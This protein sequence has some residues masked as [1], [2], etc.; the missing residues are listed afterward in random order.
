MK[1]K[2]ESLRHKFDRTL[3]ALTLG[4]GF[5]LISGIGL[6]QEE[7][8]TTGEIEQNLYEIQYTRIQ[9][10]LIQ[11]FTE[12]QDSLIISLIHDA[13]DLARDSSWTE[14]REILTTVEMLLENP[15]QDPPLS[16]HLNS[17]SVTLPSEIS[18]TPGNSSFQLE[19]GVDYSLQEY[20]LSFLESDSLLID[21]LQNPYIG[22]HFSHMLNLGTLPI[23]FNH[24]L[25]VD[26]QYLNY[27]LFSFLEKARTNSLHRVD[28]AANLFVSQTHLD[29]TFMDGNFS[30]LWGNPYSF[31]NRW[32]F[33]IRNRIKWYPQPQDVSTNIFSGSATMFYEHYFTRPHSLAITFSP[34]YYK[35]WHGSLYN[36]FRNALDLEYQYRVKYNRFIKISSRFELNN[37]RNE[38]TDSLYKNKYFQVQPKVEFEVELKSHFGVAGNLE[39]ERKLYKTADAISPDETYLNISLVPKIYLGELNSFGIGGFWE[40]LTNQARTSSEDQAFARQ[41]NYTAKGIQIVAEYIQFSGSM[42]ELEYR[43]SWRDYPY[44]EDSF[45]NSFYSDRFVHSITLVGWIPIT[46]NWQIQLF[47]NYDNDQDRHFENNDTRNTLLSAGIVYKF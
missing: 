26:N 4:L 9:T 47:G 29:A 21:E 36:F 7:G 11:H 37:F 22:I 17:Q 16:V 42:I 28:V 2:D 41:G 20:E 8:T 18:T 10:L 1:L 15:D 13:Q 6:P 33:Q 19:T 45:L 24:M 46:R 44:A 38:L 40:K 27:S 43:I 34:S 3:R 32:Y 30:Y 23:R 5:L 14:A 31:D 35:E 25:K 12:E 39:V